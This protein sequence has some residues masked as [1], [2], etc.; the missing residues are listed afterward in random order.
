M[1]LSLAGRAATSYVDDPGTRASCRYTNYNYALHPALLVECDARNRTAPWRIILRWRIETYTGI[2]MQSIG[3]LE[4]VGFT[5]RDE[6]ELFRF[7]KWT[8]EMERYARVKPK[9]P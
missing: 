9:N 4:F 1:P 6:A 8:G 5:W 7:L 2:K 3:F